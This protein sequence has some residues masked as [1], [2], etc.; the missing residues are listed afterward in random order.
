MKKE[1]K[2]LAAFGLAVCLAFTG[3]LVRTAASQTEDPSQLAEP[4][5]TEDD[6][7]STGYAIQEG[8]L[9]KDPEL[10]QKLTEANWESNETV[11]DDSRYVRIGTEDTVNW[12]LD[13]EQHYRWGSKEEWHYFRY[14]PIRW[15]VAD[16]EDDGTAFLIADRLLDCQPFNS[17]SQGFFRYRKTGDPGNGL[18]EQA[19]CLLW[20][21]LRKGYTGLCIPAFQ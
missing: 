8:D 5:V 16:L 2:K 12:S 6:S 18:S 14:D 17:K 15:R 7:L 1:W 20:N 11:I 9:L 13:N 3:G 4:V 21:R 19:Q 10:Y